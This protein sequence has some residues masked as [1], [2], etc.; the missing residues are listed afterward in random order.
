VDNDSNI[1][2]KSNFHDENMSNFNDSFN[3]HISHSNRI[4]IDDDNKNNDNGIQSLVKNV[5]NDENKAILNNVYKTPTKSSYKG[6][7]CMYT[8]IY[9]YFLH[10]LDE[11]EATIGSHVATCVCHKTRVIYILHDNNQ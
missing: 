10:L 5:D 9:V 6:T 11:V 3:S 7:Y 8:C 1:A 2:L 4:K